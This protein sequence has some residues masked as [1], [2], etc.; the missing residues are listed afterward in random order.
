MRNY[1]GIGSRD[2]PDPI[3]KAIFNIAKELAELDYE[4]RTGGAVGSDFTF[5]QGCDSVKGKK[6]IFVPWKGFGKKWGRTDYAHDEY[7]VKQE[8]RDQVEALIDEYKDFNKACEEYVWKLVSR[9]MHQVMGFDLSS[10]AKFIV[11]HT[12]D[13]EEVGGT[14]WALRKAHKHDI[15]IYNLGDPKVFSDYEKYGIEFIREI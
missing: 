6:I 13:G 9:N 4:L 15:P 10:P 7:H 2:I 14:R 11:C 12:K 5:E 8:A 3:K 1:A